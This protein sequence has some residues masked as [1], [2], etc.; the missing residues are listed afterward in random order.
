MKKYIQPE[1]MVA[2]VA[3]KAALLAGSAAPGPM[4]DYNINVSG[5]GDPIEGR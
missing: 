4:P 3:L 1:M 2:E 5:G